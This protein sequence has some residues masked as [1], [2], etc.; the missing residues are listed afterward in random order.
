MKQESAAL[1]RINAVAQSVEMVMNVL[2]SVLL[3]FIALSVI[4]QVFGR[5]INIPVVWLGEL[6][7]YSLIWLVF[8]GL[9]LGYRNGLFAQVDIIS[10]FIPVR[11]K[12]YLVIFWDLVGLVIMIMILVSNN[13]YLQYVAKSGT[14]SSE[15]KIPLY[16]VYMGPMI[17]YLATCFFTV[18]NMVNTIARNVV[19]K[20]ETT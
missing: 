7:V 18:V 13:D 6:S 4:I 9:A 10:H 16:L 5:E 17:G 19:V 12:P 1:Q 2:S 20:R 3:L 8:F 11:W 15:L 14:R